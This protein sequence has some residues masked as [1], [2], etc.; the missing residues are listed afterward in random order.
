[1]KQ[2]A[3]LYDCGIKPP[4][5]ADLAFFTDRLPGTSLF[6]SA[7]FYPIWGAGRDSRKTWS[8]TGARPYIGWSVVPFVGA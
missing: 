5:D 6:Q 7:Q 4:L 2:E 3:I 1:M 8:G